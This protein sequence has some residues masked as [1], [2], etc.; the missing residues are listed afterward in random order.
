MNRRSDA[1]RSRDRCESPRGDS[2]RRIRGPDGYERLRSNAPSRILRGTAELIPDFDRVFD[3]DNLLM[4]LTKVQESG[5]DAA[6][7]DGLR[8]SDLCRRD[9]APIF[10]FLGRTIRA[11]QYRHEPVRNIHVPKSS[12]G[13]RTISIATATDRS[14]SRAA[15]SAI[16]PMLDAMFQRMS[17]GFRPRRSAWHLLADLG[18]AV[19]A[20][21][22][23]LVI[24][25]IRSAFDCIRRDLLQ[26]DI[27][28]SIMDRRY[29]DLL[30]R[31]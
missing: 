2:S 19:A 6:G 30:I 10:E 5:G 13:T 29:C 12:G 23:Y 15:Y 31:A 26:Q 22:R 4:S 11:G 21:C 16:G 8:P 20:G 1:R 24:D 3:T 9:A 17:Y 18:C 28:R 7:G 27:E 25:D 14:V